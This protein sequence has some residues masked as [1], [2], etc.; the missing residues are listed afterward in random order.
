[1]RGEGD[2]PKMSQAAKPWSDPIQK[3]S[4]QFFYP[5]T[6]PAVDECTIPFTGRSKDTTLVKNKPTPVG[7][8]V[9][10]IAQHGYFLRW[11]RH[12]KGSP[13]TAVVV[14]LP[15]QSCRRRKESPRPSW[16]SA[17]HRVSSFT[18]VLCCQSRHITCLEITSSPR[19]ISSVPLREAGYGATG[20]ARLN[21]DI[22]KELKEAKGRDKASIGATFQSNQ[23]RAIPTVDG[24]V[25]T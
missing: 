7:F 16:P 20:T 3:V 18:Y 22:R 17:I 6:N 9:W 15:P 19:Q 8:K 14:K 2:L 25:S 13:Y 11:L 23:V 10:V 1:M 21:C 4:T 12:V 5:R 24:V